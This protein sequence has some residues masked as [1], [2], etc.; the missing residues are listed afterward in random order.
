ML[1]DSRALPRLSRATL[2]EHVYLDTSGR[3]LLTFP[4]RRHLRLVNLA[5]LA[6]TPKERAA[7]LAALH[8]HDAMFALS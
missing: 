4:L 5:A 6:V 1:A 7:R 3:Y 2:Q 8:E